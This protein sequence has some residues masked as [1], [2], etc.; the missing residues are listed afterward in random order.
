MPNVRSG[1]SRVSIET[2]G[3]WQWRKSFGR[4]PFRINLSKRGVGYSVGIPGL[5]LGRSAAGRTYVSE[6]IPGTGR[7]KI[8]YIGSGAS[9]PPACGPVAAPST[10]GSPPGVPSP[11]TVSGSSRGGLVSASFA[12]AC[13]IVR[14]TGRSLHSAMHSLA[15][16][17]VQRDTVRQAATRSSLPPPTLPASSSAP[18]AGLPTSA[19]VDPAVC[20]P[21]SAEGATRPVE[22]SE[23]PWWKQRLDP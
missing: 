5:R 11:V 18:A 23:T 13:S 16:F 2:M 6:S 17:V 3:V 12:K 14:L 15:S 1:R 9:A 22:A 19:N 8:T 10:S 4:G 20:S 21:T 7:R